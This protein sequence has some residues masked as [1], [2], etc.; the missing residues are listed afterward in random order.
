MF[1]N[2]TAASIGLALSLGTGPAGAQQGLI[3]SAREFFDQRTVAVHA[4]GGFANFTERGTKQVT[5][6]GASWTVRTSW[7]MARKLGLEVGYLGA[8][9]PIDS[10]RM[11]DAV[12]LQT[13][14]EALVRLGYPIFR[15]SNAFFTPYLAGGLGW[16]AFNLLGADAGNGAEIGNADGALTLPVGFGL[17][18]GYQRFSLDARLLYRPAFGDEMFRGANETQFTAGQNTLGVSATLGYSF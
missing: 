1:R 18:L 16:S 2:M 13:G 11:D 10:P 4:G 3:G 8:A 6:P 12:V 15:N 9:L 17:G 14:I 5:E 7:G